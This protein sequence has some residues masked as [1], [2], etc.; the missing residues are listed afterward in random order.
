MHK[1]SE[2]Q[3]TQSWEEFVSNIFNST[4]VDKSETIEQQRK[5][6]AYLE[7]NP[8]EWFKYYFPKYAYAEPAL[9]H[10]KATKRIIDNPEWYE[11]RAWSRELAKST[12]TMMEVLY[13]TLTKRKRYVLLSSNSKD[14][15][16]RLLAPYKGNLEANQRIINDYGKQQSLGAWTEDEF[17]TRSGIGFRALGAGQSPRGSRNEEARPDIL[18]FDD[19]DTDEDCRNTE[20]IIKKWKWIEEAAIGT[21]SISVPTLIIFC[22]NIIAEDCCVV[23]ACEFADKVDIVNIRDKNGKSS[24]ANKNTEEHIDRVLK[25]KSY[26]AQQKEYFNNP[27]SEGSVFKN[28]A[29]KK[30]PSIKHYGFLVCYT[31]PSFRSSQK[32]DYKATV[33]C[34]I[35]NGELHVIKTHCQQTTTANMVEGLYAIDSFVNNQV[36]LY[37]YIEKN[38]NDEEIARVLFEASKEHNGKVLPVSFDDRS[39]GDKFTRIESAL[40]P[41]DRNGKLYFNEN[42]KDSPDMKNVISQ[43]KAFSA[44]SKAHDDAPDAV[45]GARY[46]INQ[47]LDVQSVGGINIIKRKPN[48]KRF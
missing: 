11:V 31:D 44:K 41:L 30:M 39:K 19:F 29:F 15:A 8:E 40:E 7:A 18:L 6:M 23:R 4:P 38:V 43:F 48:S 36:P 27:V 26:S 16:I 32:S 10:K 25:Q 5:R 12:R 45:E 2:K 24:W 17:T 46:Y 34:G 37:F 13:L 3:L 14:N 22:G 47:K 33:L 20:M 42:E 28:L 9:F 1:P 21:R 35:H